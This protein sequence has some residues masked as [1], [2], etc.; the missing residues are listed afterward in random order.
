MIIE[1]FDE[2]K[3]F[4]NYYNDKGF[5]ELLGLFK[6]EDVHNNYLNNLLDKSNP[7]GY[8]L[9]PMMYFL[10]LINSK[11]GLFNDL[12][13]E[14]DI[15]DLDVKVRKKLIKSGIPDLFITFRYNEKKYLILLEAK[16]GSDEHGDQCNNYYKEVSEFT[17]YDEKIFLYLTLEGKE[18]DSCKNHE[19][20][21]ITYQK[22]IDYVYD[23]LIREKSN[24]ISLTVE[25]YLK[26]F[27]SL[28]VDGLVNDYKYIPITNK[29]RELTKKLFYRIKDYEYSK[30]DIKMFINN[31]NIYFIRI[32][33]NN[34]SK[35]NELEDN[36]L[37]NFP[38]LEDLKPKYYVDDIDYPASQYVY[39]VLKKLV[40][41]EKINIKDDKFSFI[42]FAPDGYKY[43]YSEKEYNELKHYRD[44]YSKD[45]YG[46]LIINGEDYYYSI[47]SL[48]EEEGKELINKIKDTYYKEDNNLKLEIKYDYK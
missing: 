9:K 23:P 28:Y 46:K 30:E 39:E 27:N 19:Y 48:S 25:E 33:L 12:N 11:N 31:N 1:S 22:L 37:V 32:F 42:N 24:S 5:V 40:N 6:Y 35:I 45:Y 10:E 15:E 2:W 47:Y 29:G 21:P 44:C 43:L 36:I 38:E 4:C 3:E 7:Y 26:G 17:E 8:G 41:D 16:L 18:P 13:N 14:N 20:Y 34:I